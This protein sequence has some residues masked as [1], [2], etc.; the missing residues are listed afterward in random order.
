[1]KTKLSI[2]ILILLLTTI[3]LSGRSLNLSG[4]GNDTLAVVSLAASMPLAEEES[5]INDIPFDTK[6]IALKS[7]FFNLEKPDA[8]AYIDDIPYDTEKIAATYNYSASR[9]LLD[10]EEYID[11]IPFNTSDVVEDYILNGFG[12]ASTPTNGKCSE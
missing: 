5:Y 6:A 11:D 9:V 10:E 8:E 12:I 7:M 3:N 2:A 4:V 1:M